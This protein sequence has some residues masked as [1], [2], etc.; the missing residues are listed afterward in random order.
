MAASQADPA[1]NVLRL[2]RCRDCAAFHFYPR[3]R[4]PHCGS[5]D[6]DWQPVSGAGTVYSYT[7][8]QRAPAPAFADEVPYVVAIVALAEGPHLM[9]RIVGVPP[10]AVRIGMAV[11]ARYDHPRKNPVFEPVPAAAAAGG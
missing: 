8:V 4:C 2:P 5:A 1:E 6:L 10:D 7:V 9:S 3:S 11:R